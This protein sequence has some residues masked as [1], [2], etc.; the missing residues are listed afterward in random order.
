MQSFE[1][2]KKNLIEAPILSSPNW[3]I[4]F[5]MMCDDIDVDLGAV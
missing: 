4:P 3:K 5:E 1:A 2:L